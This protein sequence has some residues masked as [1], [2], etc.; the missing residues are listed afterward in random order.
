MSSVGVPASA[1]VGSLTD[2]IYGLIR[3]GKLPEATRILTQRLQDFPRSRAALSLL[4]YCYY[5]SQDFRSAAQCYEELVRFHPD[6]EAYHLYYAQSLAKAGLLPEASKACGR[7]DG[8][9]YAQRLLHLQASIRYEEDELPAARALLDQ[10]VADDPE[11]I[12]ALACVTYK[13]GK[14][15][16]ARTAFAEA[17]AVAGVSPALAY[18]VALCEYAMKDYGTANRS[19]AGACVRFSFGCICLVGGAS[20]SSCSI[21]ALVRQRR[22]RAL[23]QT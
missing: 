7:V 16:A 6:V 19:I 13:E 15:A 12:V 21:E 3:D 23:L 17:V 18:N 20:R 4:G 22:E 11:T 9:Q 5:S 1:I 8:E 14:F 10:C 2:T